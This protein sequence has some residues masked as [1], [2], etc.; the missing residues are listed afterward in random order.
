M[1]R[2]TLTLLTLLGIFTLPSSANECVN[3]HN[4]STWLQQFKQEALSQGIRPITVNSALNG[5]QIDA[6][7]IKLDR[8]QQH[9]SQN[10]SNFSSKLVSTYRLNM[11]KKLIQNNAKLFRAIEQRFGVPA[12]VIAAFWGLETDFGKNMGNKSTLRSLATLAYDCRRGAEFRSELLAALRLIDAGDL[13][14]A[15]MKGAWAGEIGQT[16]FLPSYYLKYAV[17]FDGDGKRNLINSKADALASAA[18]YLKQLGWKAYQPWIEEVVLPQ[19]LPWE[20][21]GLE[22]SYPLSLWN[23]LGVKKANGTALQGSL[24]AS[25]LLPMGKDGPAFLAYNNFKSAYLTW[26][27]S[28]LYSTTAAY[29]ATRLAGAQ[30]MRVNRAP[31]ASLSYQQIKTLQRLLTKRGYNVGKIDGII[32]EQTRMAVKRV[33]QQLHLPMDAYPTLPLLQQLQK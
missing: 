4:F 31:I 1:M 6:S 24:Y 28:L 30:P 18:N 20:Q 33:Q 32:G 11:G 22:N 16:Q 9:F 23:Q 21:S 15:Q 27:E 19:N 5:I 3:T 14:V 26:N 2:K 8:Q 25:L 13:T 7:V 17:D 10:F 29:F 12:P